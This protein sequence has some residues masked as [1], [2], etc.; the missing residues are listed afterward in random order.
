M[1]RTNSSRTVAFV[2]VI[3][4][5]A[6]ACGC[7]SS[8]TSGATDAGANGLDAWTPGPD[9]GPNADAVN[10]PEVG[11]FIDPSQ[12]SQ[13]CSVDSDCIEF[14]PGVAPYLGLG[15]LPVQAGNY[16]VS[17]T[18][19]CQL[20]TISRKEANRYWSDVSR[21]PLG[22]GT[23]PAKP[24]GCGGSPPACCQNGQCT[25]KALCGS[26]ITDSG[27]GAPDVSAADG[28]VLCALH[29]GPLD[30]GLSGSDPTRWCQHQ[31]QCVPFNDGWA[32]CITGPSGGIST[33]AIPV[34]NDAGG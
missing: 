34:A 2:T 8:R 10:G 31:E 17:T 19:L 29:E 3:G 23:I 15:G 14:I 6:L 26:A 33:C 9:A 24:C 28:S 12:Y 4:G 20:S 7:G 32:C 27:S 11:C 13:V 18:C 16:C 25:T 30:S 21:T 22:S 1:Q 5:W